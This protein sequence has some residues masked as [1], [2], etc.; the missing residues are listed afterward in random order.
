MATNFVAE[1]SKVDLAIDF[2]HMRVADHFVVPSMS[3]NVDSRAA[4]VA[5]PINQIA[6]CRVT[7][8]VP[9]GLASKAL[10]VTVAK[11]HVIFAA[12]IKDIRAGLRLVVFDAALD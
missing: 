5:F 12:V 4:I 2:E 9:S 3:R 1:V 11:K 7:D 6:A 8:P 10:T